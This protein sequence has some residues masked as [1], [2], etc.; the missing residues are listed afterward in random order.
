MIGALPFHLAALALKVGAI[1][2]PLL[3]ADQ[4]GKDLAPAEMDAAGATIN[5][6]AV[7]NLYF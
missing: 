4:R 2:M 7:E 1:D 3:R 6:Y 5:W